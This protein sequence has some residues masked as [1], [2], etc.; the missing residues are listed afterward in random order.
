MDKIHHFNKEL[1]YTNITILLF[2][3]LPISIII[4]TLI[5]NLNIIILNL[6]T[7]IYCFDYN[8]WKWTKSRLFKIFIIFYIYLIL[9]SI[10]N[11]A[12]DQQL[13]FDGI[14]RSISF[15]K[16]I[17][18][19]FSLSILIKQQNE[20]KKILFVWLITISIVIFDVFFESFFGFN[21]LG[22]TSLD[23]T[24]IVS[25][26]YDESVVGGYLLAFS[27]IIFTFF[28]NNSYKFKTKILL[29]I[30]LILIPLSVLVTGE[31]SNFL[32]CIFLFTII[33]FIIKEDFL[34]IKKSKILIL[35][36]TGIILSIS[37]NQNIYIKQTEFFKRLL[38]VKDT[39][40]IKDRFQKIKYFAH[41]DTAW[42]I[43][44]DSPLNGVGS[45]NFRIK[46]ADEKYF[47]KNLIFSKTR[48]STHP[49]QIHFE[50]L[51]E[52]GL[53]GYFLFFYLIISFIINNLKRKNSTNDIYTL[54]LNFYLL[55]FL[56]PL[57]PGGGVFSSYN[58]SLFWIVFTLAN[59][60]NE[61]K[62][63]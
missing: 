19:T 32:K 15:I 9:N 46:C 17:L 54:T 20:I 56:I 50:L 45:K 43:F 41:Y 1:L 59:Q 4:G 35:V 33:L 40:N 39:E 21:T 34:I 28:I 22:F 8:Y 62:K 42:N 44:K 63:N 53:I 25:F 30:F 31:R 3:M 38:T 27:Y 37:L 57:L 29:N 14:I 16:F 2:S 5:L 11:Y 51:S 49:H 47:N 60:N 52:Q 23:Y 6:I 12:T 18:L 61:I 55:I 26:F 13:G 10:L 58:G 24:R 48:C 36:I 7:L